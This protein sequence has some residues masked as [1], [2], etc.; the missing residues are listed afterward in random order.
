MKKKQKENVRKKY[1]ILYVKKNLSVGIAYNFITVFLNF[2]SRKFFIQYIGI[3][4]LGINGL[5]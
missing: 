1:R 4:F 5:F 2:I 3:E